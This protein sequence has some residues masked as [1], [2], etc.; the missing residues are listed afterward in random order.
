MI[1]KKSVGQ[2][3]HCPTNEENRAKNTQR[4]AIEAD[5]HMFLLLSIPLVENT[6]PEISVGTVGGNFEAKKQTC[7]LNK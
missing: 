4:Y 3:F 1:A 6:A 7:K 2:K 5:I